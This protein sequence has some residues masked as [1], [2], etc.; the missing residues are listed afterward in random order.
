MVSEKDSGLLK[1]ERS[2]SSVHGRPCARPLQSDSES[3]LMRTRTAGEFS[4]TSDPMPEMVHLVVV[5][6]GGTVVTGRTGGAEDIVYC[7]SLEKLSFREI[8]WFCDFVY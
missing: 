7:N 4:E 3:L 5:D 6:G 2:T 1:A 8:K